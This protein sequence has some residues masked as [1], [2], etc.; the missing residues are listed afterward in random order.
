MFDGGYVGLSPVESG[1]ANLCLLASKAAFGRAGD[2]ARAMLEAA[3]RWNPALAEA[4][5]GGEPI[6]ESEVAVAPVDTGRPATPW[7]GFARVGDAATMIP[8]LCGDGMAMALRGAELCA[9]LAHDYLRGRSS[10]AEWEARY[11]DA[12][13]AAFE[14]PV[15]TGRLLQ[16]ML[17]APLLGDALLLAGGLLPGAAQHFVKATRSKHNLR[18]AIGR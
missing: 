7:E 17:G 5:A 16:R 6:P 15:R 9:P 18:T 12:W 14:K 2:T 11:R 13:R 8:P 3:A 1:H 10:L 4:L